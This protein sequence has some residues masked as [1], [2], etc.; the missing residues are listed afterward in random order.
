MTDDPPPYSGINPN[1]TPTVPPYAPQQNGYGAP[2]QPG[3]SGPQPPPAMGFAG[4]QQPMASGGVPGSSYPNLPQNAFGPSA[5]TTMT[6]EQEAAASAYY[7][8]RAPN[9]A[10][11]QQTQFYENPPPYS[12]LDQNNKKKQ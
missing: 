7:D 12:E 4:A 10:F 5:P 3:F 9:A 11:V 1:Y 6:K 2:Q 8:P